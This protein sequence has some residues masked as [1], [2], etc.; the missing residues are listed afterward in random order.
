LK[1]FHNQ[2]VLLNRITITLFAVVQ[3]FVVLGLDPGFNPYDSP[4]YFNFTLINPVRLPIVTAIYSSI[5]IFDFIIIFQCLVSIFAWVYCAKVMESFLTNN[6]LKLSLSILLF[7]LALSSP[8]LEQHTILMSESLSVSFLVL[9]VASLANFLR[10]RKLINVAILY[11]F[12][13]LFAGVKI[14]NSYL[15]FITIILFI[16]FNF[17]VENKTKWLSIALGSL[18]PLIFT[19]FFIYLG[20]QANITL[21]LVNTTNIIERSYD[22]LDLRRWYLQNDFPGI[23]YTQYVL[24]QDEPPIEK[25]I[26]S[27]QVK[28][29]LQTQESDLV[30]KYLIDHPLFTIFAPLK[31][32]IFIDGYTDFESIFPYL[33][34]GTIHQNNTNLFSNLNAINMSREPD[35]LRALTSNRLPFWSTSKWAYILFPTTI[36]LLIWLNLLM[37][38][39]LKDYAIEKNFISFFLIVAFLGIWSNWHFTVNYDMHRFLLPWSVLLRILAIFSLVSIVNRF[40]LKEKI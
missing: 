11:L 28:K 21:K 29:W 40:S 20:S 26:N 6:K 31:P 35:Y 22:D 30:I 27:P 25:V 5:K 18:V 23:S 36:F 4:T 13:I 33:T 14:S 3:F 16:F 39:K 9:I 12:L 19:T 10:N 2:Y 8:I 24:P 34:M 15:V 1:L 7:S 37:I 38:R 32:S 17:L